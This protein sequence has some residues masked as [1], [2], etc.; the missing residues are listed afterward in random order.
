MTLGSARDPFVRL[1]APLLGI[2][3]VAH[4]EMNRDS[5]GLI[6]NR[7]SFTKFLAAGIAYIVIIIIA[8]AIATD[9]IY[10]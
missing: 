8:I 7:K 10:V 3:V 6:V 1:T 9:I 2:D 5:G 4:S